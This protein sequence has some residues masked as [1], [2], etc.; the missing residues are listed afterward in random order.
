MATVRIISKQFTDDKTGEITP[1][2]R[3]AIIGSLNGEVLTLEVKLSKA[4]LQLAQALLASEESLE[5]SSRKAT[6]QE[7]EAFQEKNGSFLDD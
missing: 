6:A 1:Y 4:E 3:L 5:V 7:E 2:K